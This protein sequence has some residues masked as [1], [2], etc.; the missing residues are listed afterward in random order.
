MKPIIKISILLL[1]WTTPPLLAKPQ[2]VPRFQ[3][4]DLLFISMDCF[5]C[6]MIE[7][8][9]E[10]PYSHAGVILKDKGRVYVAHSLGHVQ[11]VPVKD[12]VK[13]RKRNTPLSHY[14][15]RQWTKGIS[16]ATSESLLKHF[17]QSFL[18]LPYDS[19]FLWD[20]YDE[21]GRELLYCTEMMTKLLNAFL[22]APL[23]TYP[24]DYTDYWDFWQNYFQGP[25]PQGLPGNS[26]V[27]L[28]RD[29]QLK[30]LATYD[31]L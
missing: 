17:N 1:F 18:N 25:V 9:E 23:L 19:H 6:Q 13:L 11:I 24:M 5:L 20:N 22:K 27:S 3:T 30:K 21:R 29:P 28:S 2:P 7:L 14:R 8:E 26:P 10:G 12:F 15:P 31:T 4:G 16:K